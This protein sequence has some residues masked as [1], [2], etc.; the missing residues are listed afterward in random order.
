[1]RPYYL[2][3]RPSSPGCWQLIAVASLFALVLV[4]RGF[5]TGALRVLVG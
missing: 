3:S 1:M 2:R 4:F 5:V